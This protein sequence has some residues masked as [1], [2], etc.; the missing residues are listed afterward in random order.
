M[1]RTKPSCCRRLF[2]GEGTSPPGE[3][4]K[5]DAFVAEERQRARERWNFDFEKE[6]PLEGRYEWVRVAP[7]SPPPPAPRARVRGEE[8]QRPGAGKGADQVAPQDANIKIAETEETVSGGQELGM[9][10]PRTE[11]GEE[12]RNSTEQE[13]D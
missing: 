12:Q 7:P 8:G 13:H 5:M 10:A 3:M 11:E 9:E 1:D 4:P 2:D 6:E